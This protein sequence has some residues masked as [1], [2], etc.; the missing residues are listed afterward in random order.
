[1]PTI[2]NFPSANITLFKFCD[3]NV[4]TVSQISPEGEVK[5]VPL[6]PTATKYPE[7][8]ESLKE[9]EILFKFDSTKEVLLINEFVPIP[10]PVNMDPA[11]P[12]VT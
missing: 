2:T 12:T 6:S 8:I 7:F 9:K 1:M 4:G 5:I 3:V 11:V 10:T